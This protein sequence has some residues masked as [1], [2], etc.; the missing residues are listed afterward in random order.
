MATQLSLLILPV[1]L[2]WL[3]RRWFRR[4]LLS[5]IPGPPPEYLFGNIRHVV[6]RS[7]VD[8]MLEWQEKYGSSFRV[9]GFLGLNKLVVSDPKTIQYVLSTA[10]YDFPKPEPLRIFLTAVDGE[11]L[12]WAEGDVHKRQRRIISPAFGPRESKELLPV[13]ERCAEN[14]TAHW[15]DALVNHEKDGSEVI[16]IHQSIHS[17]TLEALCEAAFDFQ[18]ESE[19][20][21]ILKE[22]YTHF[23]ENIF[24]P[25]QAWMNGIMDHLPVWVVPP[26]IKFLPTRQLAFIR[27]HKRETFK[28]AEE[29]VSEKADAISAGKGKKDIFSLL[30]RAN[31]S[32]DV[33]RLRLSEQE[34]YAQMSML[35]IAGH[36]TTAGTMSFALWELA[37]H[38]DVQT[39]LRNEIREAKATAHANGKAGLTADDMENMVYLQAVLKE[40]LRLHP[41]VFQVPRMASRDAVLPLSQPI[42]TLSGEII[43]QLP[44]PKGTQVIVSSGCYNMSKCIW[45]EDAYEFDPE[46]WLKDEPVKSGASVGVLGNLMSFWSGTK[47]C[48]GWRFAMV[49]MSCFLVEIFDQFEFRRTKDVQVYGDTL[50][51]PLVV[52]EEDKG[53]QIPLRVSIASRD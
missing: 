2:L 31:K 5:D 17:A 38:S 44:V 14:L 20:G 35:F 53:A 9:Q 11:N 1:L 21:D 19:N 25:Y 13:F 10:A 39:R 34:L 40:T 30:I 6:E 52:G 23:N 37:G 51:F 12:S 16:N 15:K 8:V 26:L 48:I 36:D 49:E 7:N 47:A 4:S 29:L 43:S 46:R 27:R 41:A 50:L 45:G 22:L 32:E 33:P 3:V 24:P 42:K 28:I 18:G